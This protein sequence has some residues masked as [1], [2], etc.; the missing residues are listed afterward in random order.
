MSKVYNSALQARVEQ[1][2][3]EK[4]LSQSKAAPIIGIG[5]TRLSLYRSSKYDGDV[6]KLESKLE[7]FFKA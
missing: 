5:E 4:G 7:E 6:A 1:F 3:K 2:L